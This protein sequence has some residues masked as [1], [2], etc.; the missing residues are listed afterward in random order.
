MLQLRL[1]EK[2]HELVTRTEVDALIEALPVSR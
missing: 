1:M 2:K